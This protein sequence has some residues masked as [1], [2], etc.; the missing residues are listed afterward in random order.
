MSSESQRLR[1]AATLV[2]AATALGLL[3]YSIAKHA[4]TPNPSLAITD[5]NGMCWLIKEGRLTST[6]AIALTPH[7]DIAF[8]HPAIVMEHKPDLHPLDVMRVLQTELHHCTKLKGRK[9][10]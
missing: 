10:K 6:G 9:S 3:V 8:H 7:G 4:P 1:T 2:A 5:H